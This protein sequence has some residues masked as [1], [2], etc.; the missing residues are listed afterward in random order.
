MDPSA[1]AETARWLIC[2]LI[3][4]GVP[5]TVK[6]ENGVHGLCCPRRD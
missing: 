2:S 1:S 4:L 6:F 3:T 5:D